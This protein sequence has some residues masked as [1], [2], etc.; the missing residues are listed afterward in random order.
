M[1]LRAVAVVVVV[2]IRS[3]MVPGIDGERERAGSGRRRLMFLSSRE[4]SAAASFLARDS[5]MRV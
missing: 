1:G 2:V 3:G 5:D 4:A